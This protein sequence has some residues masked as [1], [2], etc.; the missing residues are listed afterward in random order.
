MYV[1]EY[2]NDVDDHETCISIT[3]TSTIDSNKYEQ[4]RILK[5]YKR[6]DKGY[7]KI[8]KGILRK[9]TIEFYSTSII[10]DSLIR[11]AITG[12]RYK[13]RV[14][15]RLEEH[16]FFSVVLSTGELPNGPFI[17]YYDT[18]EQYEK[19]QS[20]MLNKDV[21]Q[22]WHIRYLQAKSKLNVK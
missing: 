14:G 2:Y 3:D 20:I 17:L 6:L 5:E 1:E 13:W 16:L 18:P 10:P 19:H 11:N 12:E 21:K 9:N 15:K 8:K 22:K 7:H 4:K